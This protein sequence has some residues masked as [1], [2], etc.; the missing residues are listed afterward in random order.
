M[1]RVRSFPRVSRRRRT[2][3]RVR[4]RRVG[5]RRVPADATTTMRSPK[6][7]P[8][9]CPRCGKSFHGKSEALEVR[10]S[11]PRAG[12]KV[13]KKAAKGKPRA[14]KARRAKKKIE[15]EKPVAVRAAKRPP[16]N[17]K[18]DSANDPIVDRAG[19]GRRRCCSARTSR[20]PAAHT[21]RRRERRAIGASA[22]QIFTKMANRWADRVCRGRRMSRRSASRSTTRA[23]ARRSPTI[24]ISSISPVLTQCSGAGR[25]SR[26]SPSSQRCEALGLTYLVSHPGNY[27]DDR[28][29]GIAPKRGRDHRGADA[30][31]GRTILCMETTAGS[32]TAIGATFED[33]AELI[34]RDP[35]AVAVASWRLRRL[36]SRLLGGLRPG[37]RVRRC[38]GAVRRHRSGWRGSRSC[39][40]TIRRRRSLAARPTRAD[41]RRIARRERVSAHHERR[42]LRAHSEGDR[43]AEGDGSRRRR[44][45]GCWRGCGATSRRLNCAVTRRFGRRS[46]SASAG[47]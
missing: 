42:A 19:L 36:L 34:G 33:L 9:H 8:I 13:A 3:H 26:S 12:K 39:I 15:R 20:S 11:P 25:S 35:G 37:A 14:K 4:T 16:F 31:P 23:F 28:A 6:S 46:T 18:K 30:R 41:R 27:I 17:P 1:R 2:L 44:M 32:G 40:S 22:M 29:S 45:R 10:K 38:V 5:D 7:G 21:R 24:R 43:D 47:R